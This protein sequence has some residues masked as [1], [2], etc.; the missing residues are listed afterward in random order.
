MNR[1]GEEQER[2]LLYLEEEARRKRR[3]RWTGKAKAKWKEH[4]VYTPQECFQR[5]SR[6]LRTTLKQSRIPMGTLEGLEEELLAFFSA[7]PHA[8]YTAMMDNSFERLLLHALC[9]YMDLASASEK[10]LSNICVCVC[11]MLSFFKLLSLSSSETLGLLPTCNLT[12]QAE[13]WSSH[14]QKPI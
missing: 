10:L 8:V 7:N 14:S 3:N 9:Q 13:G 11:M 2:F 4:A 5:I 1:S 6:R 12:F